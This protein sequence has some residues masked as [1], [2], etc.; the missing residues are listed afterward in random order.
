MSRLNLSSGRWYWDVNLGFR[1]LADGAIC[2]YFSTNM[3]LEVLL[4]LV[5]AVST[6]VAE[7]GG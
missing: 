4:K 1:N 3:L 6:S 5:G 7:A 2:R